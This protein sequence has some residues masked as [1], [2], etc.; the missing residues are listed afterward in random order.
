MH[1]EIIRQLWNPRIYSPTFLYLTE[2]RRQQIVD[3]IEAQVRDAERSSRDEPGGVASPRNVSPHDYGSSLVDPVLFA[4]ALA[5]YLETPNEAEWFFEPW[6]AGSATPAADE[7]LV[8]LEMAFSAADLVPVLTSARGILDRFCAF[9]LSQ[10]VKEEVR[11]ELH[12]EHHHLNAWNR[13]KSI[14]GGADGYEIKYQVMTHT[15]WLLNPILHFAQESKN[16]ELPELLRMRGA[17]A[18]YHLH[19]HAVQWNTTHQN[20]LARVS[21]L[22]NEAQDR[23]NTEFTSSPPARKRELL[24]EL[25]CSQMLVERAKLLYRFN[26]SEIFAHQAGEVVHAALR[27]RVTA[28]QASSAEQQALDRS[29]DR[30]PSEMRQSRIATI[31]ARISRAVRSIR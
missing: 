22:W 21:R 10:A 9:A 15:W 1:R 19:E 26:P 16:P 30:L 3:V 4:T 8:D 18:H 2:L 6:F 25:K 27:S 13:F 14:E 20:H 12:D 5:F 28:R 17:A 29:R 23:A 11:V 31:L 24:I 7:R